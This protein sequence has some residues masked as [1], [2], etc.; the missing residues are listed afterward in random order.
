MKSNPHH[1]QYTNYFRWAKGLN[2]KSTTSKLLE[3]NR[4]SVFMFLLLFFSVERIS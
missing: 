1:T 3:E 4:I 2:V